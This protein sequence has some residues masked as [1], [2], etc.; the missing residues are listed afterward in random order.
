MTMD[1]TKV[2]KPLE[3]VCRRSLENWARKALI[4]A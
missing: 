3:L 1:D 4:R 2:Q